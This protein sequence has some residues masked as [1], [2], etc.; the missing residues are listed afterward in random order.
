MS[1][2]LGLGLGAGAPA[3]SAAGAL[4]GGGDGE[5][6]AAAAALPAALDDGADADGLAATADAA[7]CPPG[8][9]ARAC[10]VTTALIVEPYVDGLPSVRI[11]TATWLSS[12]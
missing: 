5:A 8:M 10:A 12:T 3:G 7:T 11:A 9:R 6:A 4:T 1:R 2:W